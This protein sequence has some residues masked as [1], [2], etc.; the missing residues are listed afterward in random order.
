MKKIKDWKELKSGMYVRL[1]CGCE[2]FV[3]WVKLEGETEA[4]RG[5][6]MAYTIWSCRHRESLEE[7]Y[8]SGY[9]PYYN[10]FNYDLCNGAMPAVEVEVPKWVMELGLNHNLH[11][12]DHLKKLL[13]MK[14]KVIA[15]PSNENI[16]DAVRLLENSNES[17]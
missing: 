6:Y 16:Q 11:D 17:K 12:S 9:G 4:N 15:N 14:N 3:R 7:A 8:K 2:G 13:E 5:F 10:Y 1:A